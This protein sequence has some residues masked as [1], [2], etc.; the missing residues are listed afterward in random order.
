MKLTKERF[1]K[2]IVTILLALMLMTP[3]V[4]IRA[5]GTDAA[6]GR[7]ESSA[8]EGSDKEK[9]YSEGLKYQKTKGGYLVWGI[10]VCRDSEIVIPETHNSQPVIGISA[11]AFR[12]C[13]RIKKVSI[14]DS[15]TLIEYGAFEDCSNLREINIPDGVTSISDKAFC[16]C[17][18]LRSITIPAGVTEIGYEAF[19]GCSGLSSITI[20]SAVTQIGKKRFPGAKA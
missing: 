19:Y 10:G 18:R 11:S 7:S 16:G 20:P 2:R 8:D 1:L 13:R 6:A 15:V 9:N 12:F 3:D 14:P 4:G 17:S 5:A